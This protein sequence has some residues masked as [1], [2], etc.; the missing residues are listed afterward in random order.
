MST[1]KRDFLHTD[2]QCIG[3]FVELRKSRRSVACERD[4]LLF[5][6]ESTFRI[7]V[8]SVEEGCTQNAPTGF[9]FVSV[10]L[11]LFSSARSRVADVP[12]CLCVN[13]MPTYR[14]YVPA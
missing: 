11:F 8:G 14:V 4:V 3:L 10:H 7:A 5:L 1:E 12:V 6:R 13:L 9:C 2:A